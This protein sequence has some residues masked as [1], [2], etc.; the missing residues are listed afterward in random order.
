MTAQ[1]TIGKRPILVRTVRLR[2]EYFSGARMKDSDALALNL[3][4]SALACW[5][6]AQRA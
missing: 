1:Q 2:C 4:I 3:K 6:L 5:N